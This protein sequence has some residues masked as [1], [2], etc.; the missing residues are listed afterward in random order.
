MATRETG[1]TYV[2]SYEA[3]GY[4]QTGKCDT[5]KK[6]YVWLKG[7]PQLYRANC[8]TCGGA[9][10]QTTHNRRTYGLFLQIV[11]V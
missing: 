10:S 9:L 11:Q 5:C 8:P 1:T 6:V 3:P 2:D 7:K 4:T